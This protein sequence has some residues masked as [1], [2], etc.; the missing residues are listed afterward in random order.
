MYFVYGYVIESYR[1]E[2]SPNDYCCFCIKVGRLEVNKALEVYRKV[3][4]ITLAPTSSEP[5]NQRYK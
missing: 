2:P 3:C 4:T 1:L 5:H